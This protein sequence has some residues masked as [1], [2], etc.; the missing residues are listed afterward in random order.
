[1]IEESF[2]AFWLGHAETDLTREPHTVVITDDY[3]HYIIGDEDSTS[4]FRGFGGAK[5][6][7]TFKDG[8]IV[9]S[10]NLWCQG[11]IDPELQYLFK[12]NAILQWK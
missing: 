3:W 12:P 4:H 7:I 6:T 11:Q 2:K 1:M 10:T 9:N 5:V 8:T